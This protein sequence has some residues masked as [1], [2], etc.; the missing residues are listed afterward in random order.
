MS[1]RVPA[2]VDDEIDEEDDASAFAG[3][4][5]LLV[6]IAEIAGLEAALTLADRYGGNRVYI[7]RHA[8]DGHWL[9]LCVGRH[10]ADLICAHFAHPS[11]IELELPRGPALNRAERQARLRK[12]IA[13]GL[14]STEITRRL[15]ITR[16]TVTR[17]RTAL[18]E[19]FDG[20][21]LDMFPA[22]LASLP[23][24]RSEQ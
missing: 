13:Q 16:R 18:I 17:N 3:L 21:Q 24:P 14:T 6:E 19:E 10:A 1:K 5:A 15:G 7:P 22:P 20:R 23:P 11:G 8:H 9:T 2:T 12:L 4:P